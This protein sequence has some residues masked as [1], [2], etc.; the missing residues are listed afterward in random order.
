VQTH[1]PEHPVM[2]AIISGDRDAFIE[3]EIRQRQLGM[4]PPYGRLAALIVTAREKDVAER[5][6]REIARRAPAAERIEVLGPAE[7]PIFVVRGRFRWRLL[8]KAPREMDIQ[9]YLRAWLADMPEI[10]GDLR[11]SVDVDPYSFM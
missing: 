3:S 5:Y 10:K 6:A 4:L 2:Q 9:G 1:L 11:L 7:A 8:V